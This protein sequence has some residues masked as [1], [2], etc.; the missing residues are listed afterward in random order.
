M[1]QYNVIVIDN[2]LSSDE[3]RYFIDFFNENIDKLKKHDLTYT[4]N[5]KKVFNNRIKDYIKST[6]NL[7]NEKYNV[8]FDI[9][10]VELVKWPVHSKMN[11]HF[12][13]T[14]N[15]IKYKLVSICYLND[16]YDGGETEIENYFSISNKIG[17]LVI[18]D[19]LTN[20]HRVKSVELCPRYTFISW[21]G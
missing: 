18:F 5:L 17:R 21:Y 8:N 9:L 6:N 11:W 4:L 2:Y 10:N 3:C 14:K 15:L 20:K 13:I 7:I 1:R 12:D 19:G 16:D